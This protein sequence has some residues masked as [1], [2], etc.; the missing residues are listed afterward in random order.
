MRGLLKQLWRVGPIPCIC[1]VHTCD[2]HNPDPHIQ[3]G[4]QL[5]RSDVHAAGRRQHCAHAAR[6]F[7]GCRQQKGQGEGRPL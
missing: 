3:A 5:R 1:V 7:V 2:I 4:T 6:A